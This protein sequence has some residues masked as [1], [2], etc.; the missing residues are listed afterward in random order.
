MNNQTPTTPESAC[1]PLD[2]AT[3]TSRM[4]NNPNLAKMLFKK[5]IDSVQNVKSELPNSVASANLEQIKHYA[6]KLKG[7]S[8]T[9]AAGA[10]ADAATKLEDTAKAENL[11][12]AATHLSTL[13]REINRFLEWSQSSPDLDSQLEK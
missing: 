7:S 8:L 5:F 4:N 10:I 1:V 13:V 2:F 12:Q 11:E 3:L 9:V 6:H